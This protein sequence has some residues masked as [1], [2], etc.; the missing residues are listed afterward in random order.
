GRAGK[1]VILADEQ[2][3]FGGTLLASKQTINGQ[4]ASEWAEVVAAELAAMDNVLCLNRTTVFG[5]YDQN[6][7]G[8]LERRTDHDGMTAKSGTR[9]RIHRIRA[10][11]V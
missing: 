3:E 9:Q 4:P 11:Q 5:Y 10:H 1:R 7:L 2:N 6:F 8:A